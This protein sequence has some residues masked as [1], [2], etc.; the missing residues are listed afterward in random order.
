MDYKYDSHGSWSIYGP[1][2]LYPE[3]REIFRGKLKIWKEKQLNEQPGY[4]T[5]WSYQ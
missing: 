4:D 3:N 1:V 2:D 5:K